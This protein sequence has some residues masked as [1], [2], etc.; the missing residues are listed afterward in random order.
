MG[1]YLQQKF[2]HSKISQILQNAVT[3]VSSTYPLNMHYETQNFTCFTHSRYCLH[4]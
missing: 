3:F 4:C 1:G 2:P